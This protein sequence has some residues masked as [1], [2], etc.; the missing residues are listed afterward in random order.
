MQ[1]RPATLLTELKEV[2]GARR[3]PAGDFSRPDGCHTTKS[4]NELSRDEV[5]QV[6]RTFDM[7]RTTGVCCAPIAECTG[8]HPHTGPYATANRTDATAVLWSR[9]SAGECRQPSSRARA[10]RGARDV[11][12]QIFSRGMGRAAR[13]SQPAVRM[14]VSCTRVEY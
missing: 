14:S 1:V 13:M 11:P 4:L 3:V 10:V 12:C 7:A 6:R 2:A 5:W 8:S 9:W